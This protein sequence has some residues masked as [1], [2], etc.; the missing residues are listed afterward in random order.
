MISLMLSSCSHLSQQRKIASEEK[1]ILSPLP[2]LSFIESPNPEDRKK[3]KVLVVTHKNGLALA[4]KRKAREMHNELAMHVLEEPERLHRIVDLYAQALV[5]YFP[6]RSNQECV[7]DDKTWDKSL[8]ALILDQSIVRDD[9]MLKTGLKHIWGQSE[10]APSEE[11]FV[12]ISEADKTLIPTQMSQDHSIPPAPEQPS[13]GTLSDRLSKTF[14]GRSFNS[15]AY[16]ATT[17]SKEIPL[18][19][20]ERGD[21]KLIGTLISLSFEDPA[22]SKD[23]ENYATKLNVYGADLMLAFKTTNETFGIGAYVYQYGDGNSFDHPEFHMGSELY[24]L[25]QKRIKD[26]FSMNVEFR[27]GQVSRGENVNYQVLRVYGSL[28]F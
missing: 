7:I 10:C 20:T 17:A 21:L 12:A 24:I 9:S 6:E 25:F 27:I 14:S 5:E 15:L 13:E 2:L 18:I 23:D 22:Q 11:N 8:T 3:G 28:K 16:V 26:Y 19:Q 4:I 1:P